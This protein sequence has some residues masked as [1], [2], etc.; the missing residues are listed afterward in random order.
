MLKQSDMD[1]ERYEARLKAE[2]DRLSSLLA[3]EQ[4]GEQRELIHRVHLCQ[5]VLK[6]PRTPAESLLALALEDLR[7]LA[8][9]LEADLRG[10]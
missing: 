10:T 1:R 7:A 8:D 4:R 6:R 2:R 5:D 9:Q 3:A